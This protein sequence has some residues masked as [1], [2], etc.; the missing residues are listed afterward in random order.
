MAEVVVSRGGWNP[1]QYDR[2]Q[3]EREQPFFDL[4]ALVQRAPGMRVIDL[5]CGD[6]RLTAWLHR[7]LGAVETVGIDSS[8]EMLRKSEANAGDGVRF[9]K[10]D[11]LE[12]VERYAGQFDVVYSNAALQWILDHGSLFPR[13]ARL[14]RPGGQIAVQMPYSSG[15]PSHRIAHVVAAEEPYRSALGG[16]LREDPVQLPDFYATLLYNELGCTEQLTRMNVYGHVLA[17]TR[18]TVEWVKGS[19]LTAYLSR[20]PQELHASFLADYEA[21]VVGE[22]GQHTPYFYPFP[23]VFLWGRL[24]A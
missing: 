1:D 12:A 2:F 5:G 20:L 23:R 22:V 24:P 10:M 9:E 8:S 21:R 18:A 6:G 17:E 13:V 4:A 15:Q 11:I 16:W 3:A 14:A 19:L 7:E